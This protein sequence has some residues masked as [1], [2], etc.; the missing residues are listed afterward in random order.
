MFRS[1]S[2]KLAAGAVAIFSVIIVIISV[3]NFI[4]TKNDVTDIYQGIQAQTLESAYRSIMITMGDEAQEHL[5]VLARILLILIE[6][7]WCSKELFL[8]QRHH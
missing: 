4:K 5:R 8:I 6:T 2:G 3:F 7:M 1:L